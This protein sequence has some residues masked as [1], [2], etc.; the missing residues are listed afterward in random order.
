MNTD[1]PTPETNALIATD[2]HH[3]EDDQFMP[4]ST[5]WRM[6]DLA[7]KLERERDQWQMNALLKLAV[8]QLACMWCG[9]L[10]HA[11]TG[12][13]P[14]TPLNEEQRA[15]A[16]Q[17][18]VATCPAHPIRDVERERDEYKAALQSADNHNHEIATKL[19]IVTE[20]RD[21]LA[22]ALRMYGLGYTEDDLNQLATTDSQMGEITP[23]QAQREIKR[24]EAIQSLTQPTP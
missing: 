9:E 18:H 19:E 17:Q 1:T 21:R 22:G 24:R 15:Q 3:L 7:R 23:D 14:G 6:C 13:E 12:Y 20:Q 5:Y 16:H 8:K 4:A 11:P 2:Q 10:V